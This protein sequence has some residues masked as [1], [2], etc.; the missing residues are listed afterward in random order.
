V[1][2]KVM[3]KKN[4]KEFPGMGTSPFGILPVDAILEFILYY[5]INIIINFKKHK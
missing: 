2:P 4:I 3:K 5:C 1:N